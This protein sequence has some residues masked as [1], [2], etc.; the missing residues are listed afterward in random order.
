MKV[1]VIGAGPTGLSTAYALRE[2]GVDVRVFEA[3]DT[4]G[5]LSATFESDGFRFDYG[6]HEF[7][8]D[9][10]ALIELLERVCGDDLL[11]ITKRASQHFNGKF[12]RYPFGIVDLLTTMS[13]WKTSRVFCEI[14]G[15]RLRRLFRKSTNDS[16]ASWTRSRFGS[17]LYRTYFDPYTR[18]VWGVDPDELDAGTARDRISVDSIRELFGKTISYRWGRTHARKTHSEF[19]P[20]F[21]YTKG[22]AGTLHRNLARE[23]GRAGGHIEYGKRLR[24]VTR[25]EAGIESLHFEDGSSYAP[26][27]V[28][29][30]IPLPA[31]TAMCLGADA[32]VLKR[33]GELKFR[34]MAFVFVRVDK[35]AVTD[36]H[37][38]YFP[39]PSIPFQRMTEF[40]HFE[41]DMN[42]AGQ[43]GLALEIA[44][45]PGEDAWETSDEQ[46]AARCIESLETLGLLEQSDVLGIDVER[47]THAY[48]IQTKDHAAH[49]MAM[50]QALGE[51]PRVASIGRQG[52]FRY[53]NQNECLE[54]A[55]EVVPHIVS[56]QPRVRYAKRSSWAGV[57]LT[58]TA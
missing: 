55:L 37:W 7:C 5:G 41:A 9:N 18:K 13:P 39:D 56:R 10:P 19:R 16:F 15:S 1:A 51:I 20:G 6:P 53:C 22:G 58:D 25:A 12:V 2:H 8:T 48:P 47:R 14:A 24:S 3:T 38:I 49:S 43:T 17:T 30:T 4:V 44:M 23:V 31:F 45:S 35:P 21:F 36:N 28:V 54:M 27:F 42:P 11:R 26:D 40:S 57:G 32:P 29:S 52:M 50:L 46:L 34:G 33:D